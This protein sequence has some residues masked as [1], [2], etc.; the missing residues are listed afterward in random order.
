MLLALAEQA[1]L[2]VATQL[3]QWRYGSLGVLALTLLGTGI[4]FRN[5]KCAGAGAGILILL[6]IAAA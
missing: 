5:A 6:Q 3:I 1:A 4:R 2:A